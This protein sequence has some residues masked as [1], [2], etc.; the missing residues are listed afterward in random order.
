VFGYLH[1][2]ERLVEDDLRT[3]FG[4]K[5]HVVRQVLAEL[6]QMGLIERKKNIG[7]CVKSYTIQQVIDL[8]TTREILEVGCVAQIPFPVSD[9][10]IGR[11]EALQRNHDDAI[12]NSD[13]RTAFRA[14]IAF[15]KAVFNLSGNKVLT[16]LIEQSAQWAYTIRSLSMVNPKML[17]KSRQDHWKIIEAL[18]QADR[19][20]LAE[21][22]RTHLIP[23]RDMYIEQQLLRSSKAS[24][25]KQSINPEATL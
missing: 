9:V 11:I 13:L 12:A 2:R 22:C 17:E 16:D 5:R 24:D 19:A 23:S 15:H 25:F 18:R 4:L 3:R 10:D 1:P 8:Y 20:S 6:E 21:I 7:A 14:N